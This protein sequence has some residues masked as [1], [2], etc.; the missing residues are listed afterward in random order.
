[1]Q[2]A[3]YKLNQRAGFTWTDHKTNTNIAKE[4][5]ITVV[6]DK[7]QEYRRNCLQCMNRMS[8]YRLPRKIKNHRSKGRRKQL[9]TSGC[10]RPEDINKR[11]NFMLAR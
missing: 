4:L 10:E 2:K 1:V 9:K 5:N 8:R 11:P 6:L 7:I 3:E